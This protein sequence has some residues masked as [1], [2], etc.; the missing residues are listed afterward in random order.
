[1]CQKGFLNILA[2]FFLITIILLSGCSTPPKQKSFPEKTIDYQKLDFFE[3]LIEY[4]KTQDL[5]DKK[6]IVKIL[7]TKADELIETNNKRDIVPAL[8]LIAQTKD[9][10]FYDYITSLLF[11]F[12]DDPAT[13]RNLIAD[14]AILGDKRAIAIITEHTDINDIYSSVNSDV[15]RMQL[16]DESVLR[17]LLDYS[18][19]DTTG[20]G[21]IK[22][23]AI[24]GLGYSSSQDAT[25]RLNEIITNKET[26]S[27]D[28]YRVLE[29]Q[30]ILN[31]PLETKKEYLLSL[32]KAKREDIRRLALFH[33]TE[34]PYDPVLEE[35]LIPIFEE[36]FKSLAYPGGKVYSGKELKLRQESFLYSLIYSANLR[37]WVEEKLLKL[38]QLPEDR[39]LE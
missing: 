11:R 2:I 3:T 20:N 6:Q 39:P 32:L 26:W 31:T 24:H 15:A 22:M 5:E 29:N 37:P 16:G 14:L 10:L 30:K 35:K 19:D 34:L 25:N 9:P 12:K 27:S 28:T 17:N 1:M 7:E 33:L 38:K 4:Y 36:S 21:L 8:I 18:R 13:V 23:E